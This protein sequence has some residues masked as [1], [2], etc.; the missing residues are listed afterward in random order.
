MRYALQSTDRPTLLSLGS[1]WP[2]SATMTNL[3]SSQAEAMLHRVSPAGR[4]QAL[5]AQQRR[6]RA[7][8][9]QV[10][11]ILLAAVGIVLVLTAIDFAGL[12][13]GMVG[14]IAGLVAFAVVSAAILAVSR[15]RPASVDTLV[16]ADLGE[17]APRTA[18]WLEQQRA[19]LP[20]PAARLLDG[21][22]F[23]L[24]AMAPQLARLDPS[25]P[26]ADAVRRLLATEL[27]ALVEGYA[28]VPQPLRGQARDGRPSA[29]AH[30]GEGLT[31][32]DSEIAR[33]TEQ[34]ARGAF[35]ELATQNRF[36]ELKYREDGGF[37]G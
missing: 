28:G 16:D 24:E 29:D 6:Q 33:M 26:A 14:L 34:L 7:V 10:Q 27:P 36:L 17:L 18:M 21:I 22:G 37:G 32:I 30:L 2:I 20:A 3:P 13:V 23:R 9:R 5:K 4:A 31:V 12:P 8:M 25:E 1:G 35:D 11:R 15:E 19:T